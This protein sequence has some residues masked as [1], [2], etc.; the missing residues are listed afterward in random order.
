M[1]DDL[2]QRVR[3]LEETRRLAETLSQVMTVN[4][5]LRQV[6]Q[7][8]TRLCDADFAS[9]L[10]FRDGT[11]DSVL[12][13]ART[14]DA[15]EGGG[16]DHGLNTLV[17]GHVKVLGRPF[18]AKD[19]VSELG[20]H[21]P[22]ERQ[23]GYGPAL[24]VALAADGA[25]VGVLNLVNRRG[26]HPFTEESLH[27]A[28][29]TAPLISRFIARARVQEKFS[30]DHAIALGSAGGMW[31]PQWIPAV[32]AAMREPTEQM[33]KVAPT[34][35]AVL[36]TGETGTGKELFARAIHLQSPRASRAFVALNCA[37][38]PPALFES[39]LFGHEKGAFTGADV[40]RIGDLELADGGTLFLDEVSAMPPELQP[41]L[42]RALE[43]KAYRSVGSPVEKT[44]DFRLVSATNRDL[45]EMAAAGGFREDLFHRLNVIPIRLPALRERPEDI[46]LLAKEF[47]AEFSGGKQRFAPG[48]LESMK[49][50]EWRG[51]VRELRN[52]VERLSILCAS[53]EIAVSDLGS[54]A[55]LDRQRT[56]GAFRDAFRPLLSDDRHAGHI[57]R[58]AERHLILSTLEATS[59][60][61][62]AA[63]RLLGITR[64]T[65]QRKIKEHQLTF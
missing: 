31:P 38:I 49:T 56:G 57:F 10:L 51:N 43:G 65:L 6:A 28:E 9:I 25:T 8:C 44:A 60:N 34:S 42:L 53:P 52:F 1:N 55:A 3:H 48:A 24:A 22:S 63:S 27:L 61:I 11:E 4:E 5:M 29:S 2:K 19:L 18:V 47:I 32:S 41:K 20:L 59:G 37:A 58:E 14:A 45:G 64:S 15:G 50:M 23:K 17:A 62:S 36:L 54:I 7:W 12:T 46:P 30:L 33:M 16:I 21:A 35:A 39:E 40:R 26:G 13:V